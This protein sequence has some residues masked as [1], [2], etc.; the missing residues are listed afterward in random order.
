VIG[1]EDWALRRGQTYG[2]LI[3]D[4]ERRRPV[5]M[6]KTRSA[7]ALIEWLNSVLIFSAV[8]LS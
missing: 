3:C 8:A 1:V 7:E 5:A 6:L 2:T 4:L